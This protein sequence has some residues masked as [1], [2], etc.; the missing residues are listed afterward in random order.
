MA[1]TRSSI[2][3]AEY[4]QLLL[5]QNRWDSKSYKDKLPPNI[6]KNPMFQRLGRYP[7][8]VCVF[9]DPILFLAGL[10]P[11][12]EHV[13]Q[14]PAIIVDGKEMAFR[15]FIYAENV[16]DLSFLPKEPS[17]GLSTG[18]PFV[19]WSLCSHRCGSGVGIKD[20]KCRLEGVSSKAYLK[21]KLAP[22]SSSSRATRAKASSSK[23]D[24]PFLTVSDDDEGLPDVFEIKDAN[25]CHLKVSAITPL[26]WKNHLDN[27]MD[28]ELLD[29]HDRYQFS[30]SALESKVASMEAEKARLEVVEA[31][32]KKEV[33]DVK[34]DRMEVILKVVPYAAMELVHSVDLG[35]LVGKRVSY[36]VLY[37]RCATFEQVSDMK[38]PFNFSK[39]KG[40]RPSYKK[41]HSQA[42][43]DLATATFP[44][45]SKFRDTSSSA[46][47]SNLMSPPVVVSSVNPQ[48]SQVFSFVELLLSLGTKLSVV[49]IISSELSAN[50][51][52]LKCFSS[53]ELIVRGAPNLHIMYSHANFSTC[54]PFIVVSGFASTHFVECST[55]IAKNFK[56]PGA[57]GAIQQ[58]HGVKKDFLYKLPLISL[59]CGALIRIFLDS[60]GSSDNNLLR[61]QQAPLW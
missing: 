47:A 54:L 57:V 45:L 39:V 61:P 35:R 22:G 28:V 20:R 41:E 40:Y 11:M 58:S 1:N 3:P 59:Y 50:M 29:L 32:L 7:T 48:A 16:E 53:F 37:R 8:S 15:N 44:W 56:P 5:E 24:T 49:R 13:Q 30:L 33:D 38:E 25:A 19:S 14:R 31:S 10:Q 26:A 2:V 12:W 52:S 21:K 9:L 55:A 42:G 34:R 6:E 51:P 4:P 17:P 36:A 18:S 43:N 60:L 27:H 46:P 23:D